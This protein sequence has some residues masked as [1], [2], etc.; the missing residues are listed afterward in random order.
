MEQELDTVLSPKVSVAGT[1][2]DIQEDCTVTMV[3]GDVSRQL[4][5]ATAQ[6]VTVTAS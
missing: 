5:G 6:T 1:G 4:S 3:G 2:L